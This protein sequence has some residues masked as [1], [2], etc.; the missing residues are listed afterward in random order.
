MADTEQEADEERAAHAVFD[1][2]QEGWGLVCSN[3]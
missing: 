1:A 3:A 2:E